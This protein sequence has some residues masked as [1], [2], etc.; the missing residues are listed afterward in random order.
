[1]Q[2]CISTYPGKREPRIVLGWSSLVCLYS[3]C[4]YV[5]NSRPKFLFIEATLLHSPL[6]FHA[7]SM[8]MEACVLR[9]LIRFS[10]LAE[11]SG[12]ALRSLIVAICCCIYYFVMWTA[13]VSG[14]KCHCSRIGPGSMVCS[15]DGYMYDIVLVL[16][17]HPAEIVG[18]Y[19]SWVAAFLVGKKKMTLLFFSWIN[20]CCFWHPAFNF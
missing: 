11:D 5:R 7:C 13:Y 19:S 1:M 6:N 3:I 16:Y 2:F 10:H 15:L 9:S 14:V 18:I 4:I 8:S 12:L 20:A 17:Q